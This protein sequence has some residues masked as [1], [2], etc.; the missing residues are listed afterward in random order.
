MNFYF[1]DLECIEYSLELIMK[2]GDMHELWTNDLYTDLKKCK[3][4]IIKALQYELSIEDNSTERNLGLK[5]AISSVH[6][7]KKSG[8]WL[9]KNNGDRYQLIGLD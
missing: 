3:K 6:L 4:H 5:K 2:S 1:C 7:I 9:R 8:K